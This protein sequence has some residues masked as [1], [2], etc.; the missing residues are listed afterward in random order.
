MP[1]KSTR[2]PTISI[3]KQNIPIINPI[4]PM[5]IPK[6]EK[7]FARSSAIGVR[8]MGFRLF[9]RNARINLEI[10]LGLKDS[11]CSFFAS[12]GRFTMPPIS[13]RI[14]SLVNAPTVT[15]KI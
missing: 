7:Y 1:N 8:S 4:V 15:P 12:G 5:P 14:N 6:R 9:L 3:F 13:V 10:N 2:I 11:S